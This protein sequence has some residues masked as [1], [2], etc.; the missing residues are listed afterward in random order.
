MP[1]EA[2]TEHHQQDVDGGKFGRSVLRGIG[3]GVPIALVVMTLAMWRILDVSLGEALAVS[4]WPALLTG[5]FGGGFVGVVR[6]SR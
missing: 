1:P 5:G 3:A 4:A 6:A 2:S